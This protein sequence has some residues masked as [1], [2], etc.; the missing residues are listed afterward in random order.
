MCN[1][2]LL[3]FQDLLENMLPQIPFLLLMSLTLVHGMFYAER[4]QTPT[5]IKGPLASPKTQ[6]FIPYAIKSKGKLNCIFCSSYQ[7]AGVFNNVN[8]EPLNKISSNLFLYSM[9]KSWLAWTITE[10]WCVEM[11]GPYR[12]KTP[13]G[14]WYKRK[15]DEYQRLL[16]MGPHFFSLSNY[17]FIQLTDLPRL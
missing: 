9:F 15:N 1:Y 7:T 5:G 10:E 11:T 14:S 2:S 8:N 3:F 16:C 4:Y 12:N 13:W 17:G 6:F